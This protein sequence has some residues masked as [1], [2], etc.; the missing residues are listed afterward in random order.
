MMQ[1]NIVNHKANLRRIK[2][3][4]KKTDHLVNPLDFQAMDE[5][6]KNRILAAKAK[7]SVDDKFNRQIS[8]NKR[9]EH[10]KSKVKERIKEQR[11]GT[12]ESFFD[13]LRRT[14]HEYE[15]QKKTKNIQQRA[16]RSLLA[17]YKDGVCILN[18]VNLEEQA[19]KDELKAIRT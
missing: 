14:D 15:S 12:E 4:D 1:T 10:V 9:M 16:K 6:S 18:N 3:N 19:K 11:H 2:D 5:N 7:K 17:A 13:R 8:L